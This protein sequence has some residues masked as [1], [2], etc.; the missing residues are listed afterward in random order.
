MGVLC[1]SLN[2][3]D[4]ALKGIEGALIVCVCLLWGNEWQSIVV[5]M[6]RVMKGNVMG[7]QQ[8]EVLHD[9]GVV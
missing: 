8:R 7:A 2:G 9:V 3:N 4:I 5:G 6:L 1:T